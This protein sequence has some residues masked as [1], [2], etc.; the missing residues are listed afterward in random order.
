[1]TISRAANYR[2]RGDY[3]LALRELDKLAPRN[4]ET[5]GMMYHYHRAW[6]LAR[7]GRHDDVVRELTAGFA[8]QP[9]YSWAFQKRACAHGQLGQLDQAIADQQAFIRHEALLGDSADPGTLAE[10]RAG[11]QAQLQALENARLANPG[12]PTA[13]ACMDESGPRYSRREPSRLLREL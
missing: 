4:G 8:T 1:V 10:A 2:V 6:A 3:Q 7:L 13:A 11:Y 9:D 12:R 5:Q